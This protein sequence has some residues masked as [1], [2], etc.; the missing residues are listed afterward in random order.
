MG[1]LRLNR[2][3]II[4]INV[5]MLKFD[6]VIL[7]GGQSLRMGRDKG[8]IILPFSELKDTNQSI[9]QQGGTKCSMVESVAAVLAAGQNLWVNTNEYHKEYSALGF[10]T[11]NDALHAD[12]G[13]LAGPLLGILTGLQTAK[14]DWVLFSPCDTPDLPA[15]YAD[16]M[17]TFASKHVSHANVAFDGERR[18][19]LHLLLHSSLAESLLTYMLAGGRK[20]YQ[21]L[22]SVNVKNVDFSD[23]KAG[24]K[25][26]NSLADI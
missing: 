5:N 23:F 18:Q 25:N 24:F 13:P 10:T 11:I 19:N 20:P 7:A 9:E 8:L 26:I 3:L 6:A 12:I 15:N 21:W 17:T 2:N 1:R 16:L 14:S 4:A 22:H